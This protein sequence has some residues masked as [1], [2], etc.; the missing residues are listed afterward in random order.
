VKNSLFAKKG[1]S[2][3]ITFDDPSSINPD[4]LKDIP[5]WMTMVN[6]KV[7]YCAESRQMLC[8]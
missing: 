5:V 3:V 2:P 8:P 6:G 7:E 4:E 1:E